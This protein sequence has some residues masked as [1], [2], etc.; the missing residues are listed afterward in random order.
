MTSERLAKLR[1]VVARRQ[2]DLTVLMENVHK[3][4]NFSAVMRTCD[5]VGALN[6]HAVVRNELRVNTANTSSADKWVRVGKHAGVADAIQH[7]RSS[8][9][10]VMAA[11]LSPRAID[12]R[13][14]DFTKPTA[15]LLGQE[16]YGV[17][18]EALA[19]CDGEVVVP[20]LGLIASL[21]VSVAAA[22]ILYEAQR[23]REAAGMYAKA[24]LSDE[25]QRDLI[26]EYLHPIIAEKKGKPYPLIDEEGHIV[27]K[28]NAG[29]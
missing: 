7:L 18:D 1:T 17:T 26:F 19:L 4:H 22:V 28:G 8:G 20:M 25:A 10:K 23:Q 14:H 12:F 5:A 11:H 27:Y 3:P 16:L 21:N 24:Q 2:P 29:W 6:A 13:A 15:V 9:H